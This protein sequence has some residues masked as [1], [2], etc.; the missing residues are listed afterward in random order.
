MLIA[1]YLAALV[2][3]TD[4]PPSVAIQ[5]AT[6]QSPVDQPPAEKKK[7]PKKDKQSAEAKQAKK[8]KKAQKNAVADDEICA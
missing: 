1:V 5:V 8:A 2:A 4:P 7:K 6:A 3:A